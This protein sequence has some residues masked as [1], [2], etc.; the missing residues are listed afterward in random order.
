MAPLNRGK[1]E[2]EFCSEEDGSAKNDAKRGAN[3]TTSQSRSHQE[4]G[5]ATP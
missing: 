5:M 4:I 1:Q 3:V 2:E